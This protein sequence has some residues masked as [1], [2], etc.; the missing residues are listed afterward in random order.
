MGS[1][2]ATE[3][4]ALLVLVAFLGMLRATAA[5]ARVDIAL[6]VLGR[7]GRGLLRV[8]KTGELAAVEVLA[9][10]P[11]EAAQLGEVLA[12]DERDGGP[13][14]EGA[15]GAA[16]TVHV[17]LE[18]VGEV[19]VHHV[20]DTLDVDTA[21][22]DVGGDQDADLA[23]LEGLQGA[24]TLA[25]RAVGVDRGTRDVGAGQLTA[26]AVRAVLGAGEDEHRLH[27]QLRISE[28]V[29]QHD[30][31]QGAGALEEQLGDG[32]GGIGAAT[33]LEDLG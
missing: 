7:A 2:L 5:S 4:T 8:V 6:E 28:Q 3:A 14:G 19:E 11:F 9:D 22:G 1:L 23:V 31:L 25:L 27:L 29:V 10:D 18:R 21:G 17:I 20:G 24:L 12:G 30:L 26:D 15:T 33:N 13:R 16:D 32:L